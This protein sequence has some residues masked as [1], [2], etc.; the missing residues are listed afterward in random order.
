M[1]EFKQLTLSQAANFDKTNNLKA[2]LT[3]WGKISK[4][5]AEKKISR[6]ARIA[7]KKGSK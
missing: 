6:R 2:R 7:L 1:T 3:G 4:E 5:R